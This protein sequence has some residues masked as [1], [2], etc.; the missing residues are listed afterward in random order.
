MKRFFTAALAIFI[1]AGC[2]QNSQ[3]TDKDRVAGKIKPVDRAAYFAS[4]TPST[5]VDIGAV[6]P[7]DYASKRIGL[8]LD[9]FAL[10]R[11][12]EGY[13]RLACRFPIIDYVA[14]RPLYMKQWAEDTTEMINKYHQEN[15]LQA[16][17]F[18]IE[19]LRGTADFPKTDLTYD[20][21]LYS[22]V[23]G[24]I[25]QINFTPKYQQ[26]LLKLYKSYLIACKLNK[27]ARK[28]LTPEDRNFFYANPSYFL[29]PDGKR[30]PSVT[31]NVETHFQFVERA[32]HFAYEYMFLAAN[33]LNDAIRDYTA[34]TKSFS[35]E[36]IYLD[37]KIPTQS[38]NFSTAYGMVKIAGFGN[39]AHEQDNCFLVD[40][41]GDDTYT[42]NAGGSFYAA[43][44]VAV[45]IDHSGNDT[46]GDFSQSPASIPSK[47]DSS[48]VQGTGI[49]GV[50]LLVDMAGDDKYYAQNFSQGCGIMGVGAIWDAGGNDIYNG[51]TFCQGAGM[52]GLGIV[53]DSDGNDIYDAATI[54]QG[55][56]TTLGLGIV[57][58]LKGN[59]KYLLG[60]NHATN[61]LGDDT[62]GYGQGGALSFRASP[63]IKKLTAYGGVGIL[64]DYS[65]NDT[66]QSTGWCDQ[67]G[68]Y[69]MS[70]GVLVDYSTAVPLQRNTADYTRQYPDKSGLPECDGNDIYK[71]NQ[72]G[73]KG[74]HTGNGILIDKN[75]DDIYETGFLGFGSGN[76]RSAGIF[77][78]YHGNDT[79][80]KPETIAS[81]GT[82]CKPLGFSLFIDYEGTD[83][84]V[85]K[86]P[87]DYIWHNWDSYGGVWPE[88][89]PYLWP[90]AMCLDLGG[91]DDYKVKDRNNNTER[92][93][94]GHGIHLDTE[95]K[96]GDVIGKVACPLEPY[97]EF[98][99]IENTGSPSILREISLLQ[100]PDVFIR[101][102]AIGRIVNNYGVEAIPQLVGFL[103]NSTRRQF[104]RDV[105]ECIHY[106]LTQNRITEKEIPELAKLLKAKDEEVRTIMAQ[107]IGLWELKQ[108]EDAL[109]E[110]LQT[111]TSGSAR[112]FAMSSLLN[113]K[114]TKAIP[115][116]RK[117]VQTDPAED[118]RRVAAIVLGRI[119]KVESADILLKV[120]ENDSSYVVRYAAA[121]A[122][123]YFRYEKALEPLRRAAKS[124]DY[125]LRRA[126]AKG[127]AVLYQKEAIE[128]LIDSMSFRS[129]D[130]GINYG[131]NIP[132]YIAAFAGFDFPE[133]ERY[134]QIRWQEWYQQNKDKI[135]I[136]KNV[137]AYQGFNELN[138]SLAN[139]SS[140]EKI[141]KYEYFL[142]KYPNHKLAK[143][144][145]G[146]LLNEIAWNMVT[147]AKT[148]Q[149]Y[150]LVQGLKYAI[151]GA[152]LNPLPMIIDTLVEAYYANGNLDKAIEICQEEL[153]K[154]PDEAMF[155][156]RLDK[157]LKEK[158][159]K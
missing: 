14:T 101:F 110:T 47:R 44:G 28:S 58:D 117:L 48:Y 1:L 127:L 108:C 154:T 96:D 62:S 73:G 139:A 53:L 97:G 100:N 105:M 2:S 22:E 122:F 75:G 38:Y 43:E 18:A 152:E 57:S 59:D 144:S 141:T 83:K 130:T 106:F 93:S 132:N 86:Q 49:L 115:L 19:T 82:G 21:S 30:M 89:Q 7:L 74:F 15:G 27:E 68:S 4:D 78:D 54:A 156:A 116:A 81:I 66:Y 146:N 126:A 10:P 155:K 120:L 46:Y 158:E 5:P 145:L 36:D 123:S 16:I 103:V 17:K 60:V 76:D 72:G 3:L 153:K 64:T 157:Y 112:R 88:S 118:V 9:T 119:D 41:G 79:Y 71:N 23:A 25:S 33:I 138:L 31:G 94:H 35:R 90:Y 61:L 32:R 140:E 20:E 85:C 125:Y 111:D 24:P 6:N 91:Q 102:Q 143:Q 77:I 104:S 134:D 149:A 129:I 80:G 69:I 11:A 87:T 34:A 137:Q 128:I 113:L 135:D 51:N 55:S 131:E 65:G 107:N 109:I 150:N 99:L 98:M 26:E 136:K 50:G 142:A 84:Y 37:A 63:W 148:S 133:A 67:G 56:A 52:F 13:Y 121:E 95:W 92:F 8:D 45:C 12:H 114:S 29:A 40:L 42:N 151:R 39:D 124:D 147:A 159:G 70:L